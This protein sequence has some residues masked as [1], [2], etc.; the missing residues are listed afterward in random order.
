MKNLF[1]CTR[2]FNMS[3]RPRVEFSAEGVCNACQWSEEKKTF[4]WDSRKKELLALFDKHRRTDGRYDVLCPVSGGKDGSYVAYQ[5]KHVYGMTPLCITVRPPLEFGI[6]NENLT[7]FVNSGYDHLH[8]TLDTDTMQKINRIGFIEHGRPLFGWTTGILSA[9]IRAAALNEIA[10]I[11]YGEDGE[12]EYGGS[13]ETKFT[14]YFYVDYIKKVYLS[15]QYEKTFGQLDQKKIYQWTFP[16]EGELKRI[17]VFKTHWSYFEAWDSY[18]NYLVAKEHCGLKEHEESNSGTFTNFA[19]NDSS[20]YAL[21]TYLMYLKFGFGRAT[22]DANIE[23]RRGA[24]TR[25]QA[26]PLVQL[27]DNQYPERHL[28]EYLEYYKMTREEFD[29]AL[30]RSVN[31]ELFEKRDGRWEPLFEVQ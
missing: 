10:P 19:Q 22:Q 27:Y 29:A 6:G 15:G 28:E 8:I 30:D 3:T 23:I 11:F 13:T 7:D 20:L 14:P 16:D 1:W 2:C 18:R 9:V 17:G 31:R 21:H 26:K 12:M 25:E 4:D 5:L 24:L